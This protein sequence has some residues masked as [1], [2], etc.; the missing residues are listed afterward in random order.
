MKKPLLALLLSLSLCQSMWAQGVMPPLNPARDWWAHIQ[1]L[2]DDKLQGRDTGSEGHRMA[3]Q[4]VADN[5]KRAGLKPAGTNG[6]MQTVRFHS[7]RIVEEQSSLA[8]VRNGQAEP[9]TLGDEATFSLRVNQAPHI[10]AP[11]VFIGY[12]LSVPEMNYDDLKGLDLRGKV[13]SALDGRPADDSGSAPRALPVNALGRPQARRRSRSHL[14]CESQ[15]HGHSV[16]SLKTRTLYAGDGAGRREP[17]RDNGPAVSRDDQPG[18]RRKVVH[19]L[20]PHFRG[21]FRD[22]PMPGSSCRRSRCP[23]QFGR[24]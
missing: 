22:W 3:A 2:A 20:R 10:E 7:R 11:I 15:R 5:F 9:I 24:R 23:L 6:Y 19:R 21:D 12:G 16:G 18:S 8:L 14:D 4:Y 17:G 1:F 13:V